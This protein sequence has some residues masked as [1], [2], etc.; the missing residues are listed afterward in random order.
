M[1]KEKALQKNIYIGYQ[2]IHR[3]N[4]SNT[5]KINNIYNQHEDR[6]YKRKTFS[7]FNQS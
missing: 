2:H 7:S 6:V 4:R 1:E 3:Y 5:L